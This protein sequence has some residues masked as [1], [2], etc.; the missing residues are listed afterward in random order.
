M[1]Y[2]SK[3]IWVDGVFNFDSDKSLLERES[4]LGSFKGFITLPITILPSNSAVK[5]IVSSSCFDM[6]AGYTLSDVLDI[7]YNIEVPDNSLV[8]FVDTDW[9]NCDNSDTLNA[10]IFGKI[11]Y[12]ICD[13]LSHDADISLKHELASKM[14]FLQASFEVFLSKM[15]SCF[16]PE[17]ISH[18]SAAYHEN[19]STDYYNGTLLNNSHSLI[20]DGFLRYANKIEKDFTKN[21]MQFKSEFNGTLDE[22]YLSSLLLRFGSTASLSAS[23]NAIF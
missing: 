17:D 7:E 1:S 5:P 11:S 6:G 12:E 14:A 10:Y 21:F 2:L 8:V 16:K 9:I 13:F 18:F 19:F 4:F 23:N 22:D 20:S 15:G 3:K